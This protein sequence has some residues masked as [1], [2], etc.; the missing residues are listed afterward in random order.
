MDPATRQFSPPA[1]VPSFTIGAVVGEV[2]EIRRVLGSGGMG[3]VYEAH[4]RLLNRRVALKLS[5]LPDASLRREAQALAA[6]RHPSMVGVYA[7]GRHDGA[8]FLAMELV[9]GTTL[10]EHM[11]KQLEQARP[12][13]VAEAVDILIGVAEGLSAIHA[14]GISHR[15]V[16][17]ANIM[18]A[19]GNRTVLMDF[20]LF[21]PEFESL[22][23]VAGSPEYMAPEVCAGRVNPGDGHLVDLYALGIIAYELLAGAPPF[24]GSEPMETLTL[25]VHATAPG[26]PA[27]R[28]DVPGELA[29]LVKELLAKKP[30]DRPANVDDVLGRLRAIRARGERLGWRDA[31]SVLIVDDDRDLA[32]T[33]RAVIR[34]AA[35]DAEVT[36][37]PD[38]EA[39]FTSLLKNVPTLLLL[40]LNMPRMN[41]LELC[42]TLRGSGLASSCRIV[43]IAGDLRPKDREL[44]RQ[45]G[46]TDYVAKTPSLPRALVE[47]VKDVRRRRK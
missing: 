42:M 14:S 39:A 12:F 29:A 35:P 17:P 3:I 10:Y 21:K 31:L 8:E 46:V 20:G 40:D 18:L 6:I 26:L 1:R 36:L 38:G 37:A 7:M 19:P 30:N 24:R 45:L 9:R 4:D 16:K 25:H 47:I 32:E 13:T 41:G 11:R 34:S 43:S 44:L 27:A 5:H 2:Y 33:L 23:A 22:D 15:D 28:D